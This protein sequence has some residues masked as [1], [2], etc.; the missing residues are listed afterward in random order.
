MWFVVSL[1]F[2][3]V[4]QTAS[5]VVPILCNNSCTSK[6]WILISLEEIIQIWIIPSFPK[7]LYSSTHTRFI[8]ENRD[9]IWCNKKEGLFWQYIFWKKTPLR[10][11]FFFN[12]VP[13]ESFAPKCTFSIKFRSQ[14]KLWHRIDLV[15]DYCE[16]FF[17][18]LIMYFR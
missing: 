12:L 10:I 3:Q 15:D 8:V 4:H 17:K 11:F 5:D 6:H 13:K 18:Y 7:I 16:Q 2:F 9:N 14:M 1:H